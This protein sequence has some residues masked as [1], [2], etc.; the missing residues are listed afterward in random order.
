MPSQKEWESIVSFEQL[1]QKLSEVA[2]E[3][4]VVLIDKDDQYYYCKFAVMFTCRKD[5]KFALGLEMKKK[6]VPEEK[7]ICFIEKNM[8]LAIKEIRRRIEFEKI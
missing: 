3:P 1:Y 4:V 2:K 8:L 6:E 7:E 5:E